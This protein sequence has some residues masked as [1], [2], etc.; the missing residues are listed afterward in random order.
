VVVL[1]LVVLFVVVALLLW[2]VL[3]VDFVVIF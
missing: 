1:Q 3:V 2:E